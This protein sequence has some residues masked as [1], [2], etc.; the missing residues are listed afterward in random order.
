MKVAIY[1]H[2]EI[3]WIAFSHRFLSYCWDLN[4]RLLPHHRNPRQSKLI[5]RVSLFIF[6]VTYIFFYKTIVLFAYCYSNFD[7]F[8]FFIWIF[9]VQFF[10]RKFRDSSAM[11]VWSLV[12][13]CLLYVWLWK[14]D[15]VVRR[16]T[17]LNQEVLYMLIF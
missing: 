7:F 4:F 10:R 9:S 14:N 15:K 6:S 3:L 12:I 17:W 8:L 5:L 16:N 2:F 1:L 11:S 13:I